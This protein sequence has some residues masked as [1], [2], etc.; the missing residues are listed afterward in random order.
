MAH[1]QTQPRRRSIV[2]S[3][4]GGWL[5]V[6]GAFGLLL[7]YG[8]FAWGSSAAA[9]SGGETSGPSLMVALPFAA[10]ALPSLILGIGLLQRYRWS[11]YLL[12]GFFG[13]AVLGTLLRLVLGITMLPQ[14]ANTVPDYTGTL[15]ATAFAAAFQMLILYWLV[16]RADEFR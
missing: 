10:M 7:A 14:L 4:L 6:Q 9:S 12:I 3:W 16:S 11:L 1:V 8:S 15:G 5:L 2:I 13:L